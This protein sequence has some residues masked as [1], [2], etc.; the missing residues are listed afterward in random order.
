MSIAAIL[1]ALDNSGTLCDRFEA[2]RSVLDMVIPRRRR[3]GRSYQGFIKALMKCTD[4]L[5]PAI[6]DHL[7]KA[8]RRIAGDHWTRF[9]WVIFAADGSKIDCVRS[10]ANES[11]FGIAGRT[12]SAPQQ[13]LTTLWHM[14][15]GLPWAWVT[16]RADDAERNHLRQ[17]IDLLP[18]ACLLVADAGFTG[19]DL[20]RQL[21]NANVFFLIRVGANVTLLR[22]LGYIVAEHG[23][24]VYLWPKNRRS[25]HPF[26]L[27]LICVQPA[28]G[29][30]PIF[31]IT[32]VL[33]HDKLSDETAAA[34]YQ[35]RWG[36]EVFFRS[37]KQTL[38]RRKM[39]SAAPRQAALELHWSIMG[40]LLLGLVSVKA[41][42]SRGKDPLCWSLAS[43]L[44]VVR[45][46]MQRP[47]AYRTLVR[48]LA[49][50]IK[51]TYARHRSKKARNWA[52]KK[53]D[54]PPGEPK[55]RIANEKEVRQAQ[56]LTTQQEAA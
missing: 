8:V 14:G 13:L 39:R 2:A 18:A 34:I 31:L 29:K 35:M 9:G 44:R 15:T 26:V 40:L 21:Q 24:T 46:A 6:Q 20:L 17:M 32:N 23:N 28:G 45:R 3:V 47:P 12:K 42:D 33:D 25:D 19:F 27:R 16:G 51:D 53:N 37:L 36:V 48:H 43:A 7:R 1:M 30:K 55:L 5:L 52:H 56:Q 41:I 54:P 22:K 38:Q 10:E 49:D 11:F 4:S 50:A